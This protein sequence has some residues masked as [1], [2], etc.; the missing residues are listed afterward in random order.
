MLYKIIIFLSVV[1]FYLLLKDIVNV[2][3][4]T[5]HH[6]CLSKIHNETISDAFYSEFK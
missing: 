1:V 5:S 4:E 2:S 6:Q 3:D